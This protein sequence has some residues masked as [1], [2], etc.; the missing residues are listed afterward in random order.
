MLPMMKPKSTAPKS[1]TPIVTP[2]SML[3]RGTMSPYPM[4]VI[5][6]IVQ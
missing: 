5:V 6:V 1:C 2:T 3:V 4:V